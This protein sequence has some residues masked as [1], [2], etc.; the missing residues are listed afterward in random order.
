MQPLRG[1]A[2][3]QF[4]GENDEALQGPEVHVG[5]PGWGRARITCVGRGVTW[6][7]PGM[8]VRVGDLVRGEDCDKPQMHNVPGRDISLH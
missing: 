5:V 6:D 2:E 1:A 8:A 4:L 3:V 7:E